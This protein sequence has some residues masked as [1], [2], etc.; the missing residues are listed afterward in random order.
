MLEPL[1]VSLSVPVFVFL[2]QRTRLV[3][4]IRMSVRARARVCA[5]LELL[6]ALVDQHLAS[7][8]I[9][10]FSR[11]TLAR[12]GAGTQTG[13]SSSTP[14]GGGAAPPHEAAAKRRWAGLRASIGVRARLKEQAARE[15]GGAAG[16]GG[17]Q[18]VLRLA[19][20]VLMGVL[21]SEVGR[22][23]RHSSLVRGV[24]VSTLYASIESYASSDLG[25]QDFVQAVIRAQVASTEPP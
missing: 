8:A 12:L 7:E 14:M 9:L 16:D 4:L 2:S 3:R 10:F 6:L 20:D 19:K 23:F 5:R 1:G 18:G 22:R 24:D 13:A 21:Q 17:G 25:K 11:A 15:G